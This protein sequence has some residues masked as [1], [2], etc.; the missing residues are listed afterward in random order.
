MSKKAREICPR[1]DDDGD[2]VPV[3]KGTLRIL[4]QRHKNTVSAL[5]HAKRLLGARRKILRRIH[6]V[7]RGIPNGQIDGATWRERLLKEIPKAT[8]AEE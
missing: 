6:N 5:E 4:G 2:R 8:K 7:I 1:K 3:P